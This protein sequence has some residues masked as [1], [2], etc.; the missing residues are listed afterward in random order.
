[1]YV[2]ALAWS[3]NRKVIV[4]SLAQ[5]NEL[6]PEEIKEVELLGYGK[7]NFKR[8]T[9]GLSIELPGKQLNKIAPVFKVR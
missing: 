7:V 1:M 8:T 3:E 5:G 2:T 6:Y 9:E 4:K